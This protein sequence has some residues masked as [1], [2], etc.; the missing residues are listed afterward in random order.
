MALGTS[1]PLFGRRS[2]VVRGHR[3]AGAAPSGT[4]GGHIPVLAHQLASARDG[5][6]GARAPA[7]PKFPEMTARQEPRPPALGTDSE[8]G[9]GL[10]R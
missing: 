7:E 6:R 8:S 4:R 10:S 1:Q 5:F 9:R 2:P 3:P